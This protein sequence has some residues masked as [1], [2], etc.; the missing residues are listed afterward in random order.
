MKRKKEKKIPA[1]SGRFKKEEEEVVA[2]SGANHYP[3]E[4]VVGGGRLYRARMYIYD[5]RGQ[6]SLSRP[7]SAAGRGPANVF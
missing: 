1:N 6:R 5:H 7:S 3:L 2:V 4:T